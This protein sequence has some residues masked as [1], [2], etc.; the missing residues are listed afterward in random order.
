MRALRLLVRLG[1]RK[2]KP[3][4]P[5][6]QTAYTVKAAEGALRSL[7]ARDSLFESVKSKIQVPVLD[8]RNSGLKPQNIR[9]KRHFGAR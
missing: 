8:S 3:K 4:L 2:R 7:Q 9:S 6:R 1:L 5:P